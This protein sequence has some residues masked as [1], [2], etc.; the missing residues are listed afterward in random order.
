MPENKDLIFK[1]AW[2]ARDK[3]TK[4]Q[5]REIR[6]LYNEWAREVREQANQ[7]SKVGTP[8]SA[9]QSRELAQLY[10][11]LRSGS[12][13]LT[14]EI[15]ASVKDNVEYMA[16]AVTNCN[17][18]WLHSLGFTNA[19]ID[20][21]FSLAKDMSIRNI[22]TGNVYTTGYSLSSRLWQLENNTMK[23]IYSVVAKG[24]AQNMSVYD[25]A[26]M[27]EKY[28][29][30]DAKIPYSMG[31]H[32]Q[33]TDYSAQRLAR[34]LI[35]H[36][37]QQTLVALT[38]DNPFING[39]IWHATSAHSCALCDERDGQVYSAEDLPLDHPNGMCSMEPNVDFEK[40][41]REVSDWEAGLGE[42]YEFFQ[43]LDF[44]PRM[45]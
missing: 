25:I 7:I 23:D 38:K 16:N 41:I 13:Q 29:R 45:D 28:I 8:D 24:I 44:R 26:K 30:P 10:Y 34:T 11:Q 35:Q 4:R 2:E 37:Y 14:A 42:M 6:K 5:E 20:T 18:R 9:N 39:Y 22:I 43:D 15:N 3:I 36:A 1:D 17:K 21:K 19:S 32:Q 12:K 31:V 40:M 27:L 33:V